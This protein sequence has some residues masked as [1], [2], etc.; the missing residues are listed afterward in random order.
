[1]YDEA[2]HVRDY[3]RLMLEAAGLDAGVLVEMVGHGQSG[4]IVAL[5][6]DVAV[7]FAPGD[8]PGNVALLAREIEVA[9][10]LDGRAPVARPIWTGRFDEG[11]LMVAERA[12]GAAVSHLPEGQVRAGLVATVEAM[13]HLHG[14]DPAGCPFD[15]SLAV[16]LAQAE[17]N[18]AE[19]LV[20]EEDFD[21]E[22]A[23][24][25]ARQ[26]LDAA[27]AARPAVERLVLTHGDASLPNFVW[28]PGRSPVLVD[29]GRFGLADPWQDLALFLRSAR[30]N[31]PDIDAAAILR[32]VYPLAAVDEAACAFYR[33]MDEF[34]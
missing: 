4:D 33:L 23:G 8:M 12:A 29:L 34:F 31:Y 27:L 1:M 15:M 30:F 18:V 10:W 11:L 13:A 26:A 28:T 2:D 22:R 14:L 21:D 3:V 16:K 5:T 32:E 25:T 9:R 20:D 17:R 24:W 19:G 6:P 7:K